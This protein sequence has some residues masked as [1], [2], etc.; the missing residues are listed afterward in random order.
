MTVTLLAAT[1]CPCGYLWKVVMTG[2]ARVN[3][4]SVRYSVLLGAIGYKAFRWDLGC[5]SCCPECGLRLRSQREDGTE[6]LGRSGYVL[7]PEDAE[8]VRA[9]REK[10]WPEL[11]G[12]VA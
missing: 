12:A 2:S 4:R 9:Y 5:P 11:A 1:A 7:R 6:T 8:R 3:K 10:R